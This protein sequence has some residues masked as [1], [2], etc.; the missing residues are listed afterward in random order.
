MLERSPDLAAEPP[1][2]LEHVA[3]SGVID[4]ERDLV[5]II[6]SAPKCRPKEH[7]Q[8]LAYAQRLVLTL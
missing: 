1:R 8:R 5:R 7:E 4:L 6:G 3:E 2:P